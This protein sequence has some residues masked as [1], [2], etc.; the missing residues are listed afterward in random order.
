MTR[1]LASAM[2]FATFLFATINA[3]AA[4]SSQTTTIPWVIN[5]VNGPTL[6]CTATVIT[7]MHY[8]TDGNGRVIMSSI[9]YSTHTTIT[10]CTEAI[11]IVDGGYTVNSA[12]QITSIT[13]NGCSYSS[14]TNG[15]YCDYANSNTFANAVINTSNQILAELLD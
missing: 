13:I 15:D 14:Q 2:L 3:K 11:I 6:H 7:T 1:L 9:W 4:T 10:D 8:D 12:N 5:M